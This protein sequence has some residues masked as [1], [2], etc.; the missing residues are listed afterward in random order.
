[1]NPATTAVNS[2]AVKPIRIAVVRPALFCRFRRKA[3]TKKTSG[4]V[5]TP[6]A[7]PDGTSSMS[8]GQMEVA[9][10]PLDGGSSVAVRWR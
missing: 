5:A 9:R 2:P 4:M 7:T 3:I 8:D 10:S 1:M 6:A